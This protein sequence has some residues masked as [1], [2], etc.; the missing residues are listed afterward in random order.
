MLKTFYAGIGPGGETVFQSLIGM[1]KTGSIGFRTISGIPKVSIPHRYAEN[2][3]LNPIQ[4]R[5]YKVSIP[6]RYAENKD[7]GRIDHFLFMFQSLIGMLKT[8]A[9]NL[10]CVQK[11]NIVSIP[12]RYAENALRYERL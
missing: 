10:N 12:H 1:L 6:H 7:W 9:I 11:P 4:V 8:F 5:I 3:R 2:D